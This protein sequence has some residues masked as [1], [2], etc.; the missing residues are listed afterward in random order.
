MALN[1]NTLEA[2]INK[3]YIPKLVDNI[4][5]D[6]HFLW[7]TLKEKM[8]TYDERKIVCPLEYAD[9]KD[10]VQ[11]L[12]EYGVMPIT[13]VE[14]ATAAE[15]EP[16]FLTGSIMFTKKEQLQNMSDMAIKD[17]LK[18]K[19][20]NLR[21]SIQEVAATNLWARGTS[22]PTAPDWNSLDHLVNAETGVAVGGIPASG[23]T[24]SWW[25]SKVI[26]LTGSD[27]VGDPTKEADLTDPDSDVYIMKIIQRMIAKSKYQTG[28]TGDLLVCPQYIWDLIEGILDPQKTGSKMDQDAAAAGFEVIKY[29]KIKI[30]ADDDMVAAQT[31]GTDG[32]MYL[33]NTNYLYLFLNSGANFTAEPFVRQA[34]S[35]I[36]SSLVNAYGNIAISNRRAQV[37]ATGLKSS[38]TYST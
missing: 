34:N 25:L 20:N 38:K 16:Q 10:N 33:L 31:G 37:V 13:P 2:L 29:R 27:Y 23:T 3:Y 4:F 11:T 24:P 17:V 14:I 22:V 19:M 18:V 12:T 35:N 15:Y 7:F 8:R 26:D 5:T 30:V 1:F 6:N 9:S 32:R 21:K 36:R 28:E